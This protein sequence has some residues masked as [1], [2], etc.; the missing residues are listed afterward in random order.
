MNMKKILLATLLFACAPLLSA[1]D[2]AEHAVLHTVLNATARANH[3]HGVAPAAVRSKTTGGADSFAT[4]WI[5]KLRGN[6]IGNELAAS[7]EKVNADQET[8][9][10]YLPKLV[11]T[12]DVN[13]PY[14]WKEIDAAFP[15][16]KS[17]IVFSRPAFDSLGSVAFVRVDVIPRAGQATTTFYELEHQPDGSWKIDHGATSTYE[18]ARRSDV[19]LSAR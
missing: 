3:I 9:T 13:E 12:I 4:Q 17:L 14:D 11:K 15:R 7:Y 18:S 10:N 6:V 19:H 5:E 2:D 8:I 1:S 16:A